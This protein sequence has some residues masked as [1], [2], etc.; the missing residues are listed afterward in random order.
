MSNRIKMDE[1]GWR[2]ANVKQVGNEDKG[3]EEE[4]E[5]EERRGS[6]EAEGSANG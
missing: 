2:K 6:N 1:S 3:E 4:E 5:E